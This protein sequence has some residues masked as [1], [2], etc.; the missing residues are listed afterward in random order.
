MAYCEN[1]RDE[2]LKINDDR[3]IKFSLSEL[4]DNKD[5]HTCVF[6]MVRVNDGKKTQ[7]N[8]YNQAWFRLQNE[9]TNQTLDFSKFS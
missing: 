5:P 4:E 2:N 9:D 1:F 7:S 8:H 6:L 3:K